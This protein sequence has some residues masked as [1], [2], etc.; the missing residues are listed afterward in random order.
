M[1]ARV[2]LT[3]EESILARAKQYAASNNLSLSEMVEKYFSEVSEAKPK[4]DLIEY[5]KSLPKVDI[6]E[7]I[8]FKKQ[9]FE[10]N[11]AKYGF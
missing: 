10:D 3:I 1:K 2:N 9:Y 11:A 8:D 6:D 4:T 5:I 7:N